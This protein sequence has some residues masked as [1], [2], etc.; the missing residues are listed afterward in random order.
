LRRD[1]PDRYRGDRVR[2]DAGE[3]NVPLKVDDASLPGI[4]Q[5]VFTGPITVAERAQA[6]EACLAWVATHKPRRILVDF[7][8][9]WPAPSEADA[10]ARH[11]ENLAK[12]YTTL[13]GARIAYLSHPEHRDP[14]P[15]E[16]Q[17]AARGYFYQ[18]FTDRAAALRWLNWDLAPRMR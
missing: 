1:A 6:F 11:A 16:L 4:L 7:T 9:G 10:T 5:L 8:G 13:G 18:R 15:I 14:S 17:A 12:A 3:E 2:G